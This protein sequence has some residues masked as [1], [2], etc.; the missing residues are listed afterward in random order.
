ML[1]ILCECSDCKYSEYVND[2]TSMYGQCT[3]CGNHHGNVIYYCSMS[4]NEF[5]EE[6]AKMDDSEISKCAYAIKLCAEQLSE[7][8]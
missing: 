7:E 3:K 2:V 1:K 5:I 8:W 4:K 6:L